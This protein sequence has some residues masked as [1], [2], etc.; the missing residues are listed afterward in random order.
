MDP[1]P[2]A[3]STPATASL[4]AAPL[5]VLLGFTLA[6]AGLGVPMAA[7]LSDRPALKSFAVTENNGSQGSFPIS[8]SRTGES[9]G[10][11]SSGK[12]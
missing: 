10:G 8:F 3:E 5:L 12:P 4:V 9:A 1:E 2:V 11:D 6:I 7:V